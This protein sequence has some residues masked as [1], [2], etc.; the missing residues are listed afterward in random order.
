MIKPVITETQFRQQVID[1]AKVFGFKTY[2]TWTSIH[3]P[4]GFPDLVLRKPPRIIFAELKT[5]KGIVTPAQQEWHDDL[6]ACGQ[7]A[8]IWRPSDFEKIVEALKSKLEV[9]SPSA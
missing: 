8:Y 1:L 6:I 4:K 3:S 7:E 2:F 9:T 5:D